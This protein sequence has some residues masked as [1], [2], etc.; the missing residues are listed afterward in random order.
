MLVFVLADEEFAAFYTSAT[1][2]LDDGAKVL[3]VKQW[4]RQL[5]VT[6]VAWCL[7]VVETIG[8]ADKSWLKDSHARVKQSV[9]N[10]F[11]INVSITTGYLCNRALPYLVRGENAELNTNDFRGILFGDSSFRTL[12][13]PSYINKTIFRLFWINFI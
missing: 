3:Y 2:N 4:S 10:G 5:D 9:Y 1:Q 7:H 11:I 12:R 8:R 13:H 6:E